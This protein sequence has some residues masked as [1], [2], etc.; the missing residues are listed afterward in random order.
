[1]GR[2]QLYA[3][4]SNSQITAYSHTIPNDS[5][6]KKGCVWWHGPRKTV[7]LHWFRLHAQCSCY[8]QL[9]LLLEANQLHFHT[10][11]C[12]RADMGH[13]ANSKVTQSKYPASQPNLQLLA[14]HNCVW[15]NCAIWIGIETSSHAYFVH[16]Q[17][18]SHHAHIDLHTSSR[19]FDL[20]RSMC[21]LLFVANIFVTSY[22]KKEDSSFYLLCEC[23]EENTNNSENSMRNQ[24]FD[25][26][27]NKPIIIKCAHKCLP[28]NQ[29]GKNCFPLFFS[30]LLLFLLP[31]PLL[32]L[33]LFRLF[34]FFF[35]LFFFLSFVFS[36]PL[37]VFLFFFLLSTFWYVLSDIYKSDVRHSIWRT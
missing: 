37:L 12:A 28:I 24:T 31:L 6:H 7:F 2:M 14:K 27:N 4:A 19:T 11:I 20:I 32:L 16:S 25:S 5:T 17:L 13:V 8:E 33:F 9:L 26:S 29:F 34:F 23:I 35:F 30:L 22:Q 1:M 21:A 36:L 15:P 18:Q 10:H 3:V